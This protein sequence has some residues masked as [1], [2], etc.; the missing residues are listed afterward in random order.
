MFKRIAQRV[1]GAVVVIVVG[2]TQVL[3]VGDL[4]E[5]HIDLGALDGV[6]L[7]GDTGIVA[8]ELREEGQLGIFVDVPGQAWR[9]VVALVIHVVDWRAAI[10]QYAAEAVQELAFIVDLAR[11]GEVDLA[12][13]VTAILQLDFIAGFFA[14]ATADHI[15]QATGRRLA[16]E[17]RS[18]A[19]QQGDAV[20][21]PGFRLRVGIHASWQRQAVEELGR[22]KAAYTQ[23]VD[24]RVAAEAAGGDAGHVAHCII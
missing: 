11:A 8:G 12:V 24:A 16:V 18:R 20:Q 19:T 21:V 5:R 6:E 15:Q 3:V 22:F 9:D 14:R 7:A 23:P 4:A 13:V 1:I 17:R 2:V 10:T